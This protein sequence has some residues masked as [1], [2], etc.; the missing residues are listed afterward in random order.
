MRRGIDSSFL[1]ALEIREHEQHR[2]AHELVDRCITA[3]N[4]FALTPEILAEFIHVACD[5]RR[6]VQPLLLSEAL[7]VARDWWEAA[8]TEQLHTD[9]ASVAVFF[10]WMTC[11]RLGRK[12]ILDTMLAATLHEAGVKSLLTLNPDDFRIFGCFE[13]LPAAA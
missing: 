12:R 7:R 4:R 3:G 10:D 13:L 8:E 9:A 2:L 6:F 1:I 5:P 11:H